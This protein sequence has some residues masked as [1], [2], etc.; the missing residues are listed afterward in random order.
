MEISMFLVKKAAA[1][2]ITVAML[3]AH[4]C[5]SPPRDAV[6]APS[7]DPNVRNGI[8]F[9]RAVLD[10]PPGATI[11]IPDDANVKR[12]GQ[13][14]VVTIVMRKELAFLGHPSRRISI[15]EVRKTMGVALQRQGN[16]LVFGTVGEWSSGEGG[17]HMTA[18]FIVP[19]GIQVERRPRL[20]GPESLAQQAR[21]S[22]Q[23]AWSDADGLRWKILEEEREMGTKLTPDAV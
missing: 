19:A 3:G 12:A 5:T 13:S 9:D 1:T 16:T 15:D 10:V 11:V 2:F 18:T 22:N 17:A 4:G 7:A 6:L 21:A 20:S 14:G 8:A 23:R